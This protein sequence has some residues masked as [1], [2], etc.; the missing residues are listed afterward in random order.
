MTPKDFLE[1]VGRRAGVIVP[2]SAL[3]TRRDLGIGYIG[4]LDPFFDWMESAGLSVLSLLPL[5]D[6]SPLDSCPYSAISALALDPAYVCLQEVPEIK[7]SPEA[8]R[9]LDETAESREAELCRRA[10]HVHFGDARA[11]KMRLLEDAYRRF[12]EKEFDRDTQRAHEFLAFVARNRWL[13][14]YALFKTLKEERGWEAWHHWPEGLR[15]R[16]PRMLSDYRVKHAHRIRFH[17]YVQWLLFTQWRAVRERANARGILL[18]GDLPFGL[19]RESAEV[20]SRREDFDI[21]LKMGAPPDPFSETGQDWGLPAYRWAQMKERGH[22]FWKARLRQAAELYDLYRLDHAIG[23]FRTWV[24]EKDPQHGRFDVE[25]ESAQSLRG[26]EF[27]RMALEE[28]GRSRPVA[29]DLGVIP[30]FLREVLPRLGIPGYKVARWEHLEDNWRFK[31]PKDFPPLS[32]AVAG[33]H[34]TEPLASWWEGIPDDER[35]R[36]W[37]MVVG[38]PEPAPPFAG[39]HEALLRS[40]YGAGSALALLQF[41]DV[42]GTKE[43]VNVPATVGEHN[44]TYRV[45]CAAEDLVVLPQFVEGARRLK[46]LAAESGRLIKKN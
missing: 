28:S 25:P 32:M 22:L 8:C 30:P 39:A 26:E 34:D 45:P 42:L 24:L 2:L 9:R 17:Q 1:T 5:N 20:W 33:T 43:R 41:Q 21:A 29:E 7:H 16:D 6:L 35:G 36:Y 18:F 10:D 46:R 31:D 27:M 44:W 11:L 19:S 38:H 13:N 12:E 40:L 4:A 15:E 3:R 37:E 23:Y 14:D